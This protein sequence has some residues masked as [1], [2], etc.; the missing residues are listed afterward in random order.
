MTLF[1]QEH[2]QERLRSELE[3]TTVRSAI[4]SIAL[5]VIYQVS[6]VSFLGF[7]LYHIAISTAL[8]LSYV[9]RLALK[10]LSN[11]SNKEWLFVHLIVIMSHSTFWS[12]TLLEIATMDLVSPELHI[13]TYLVFAGLIAA[14]SYTLSIS[15]YDFFA[16]VLPIL[17]TQI[18]VIFQSFDYLTLKISSVLMILLF[19]NFLIHQRRRMEKSW[20]EQRTKNFEMQ[21]I[22]DAVPG[23]LSVLKGYNY[24]LV[25]KYMRQATPANVQLIGNPIGSAWNDNPQFTSRIREFISSKERRLQYETELSA[26]GEVRTYLVTA[27]KSFNDETIISIIDIEEVKQIEREMNAQKIKLQQSAKMAAL[28][29]MASGLAHEINNPVAIISGRA[30]QL[31]LATKKEMATKEVLLKGLLDINTTAERINRIVKGLRSFAHDTTNEPLLPH[32]LKDIVEDTLTFCEAK[33]RNNGIDLS[34]SIPDNLEILCV[35][36]QISQVILNALNN[37]HDAIAHEETNKWIRI[38]AEQKEDSIRISITDS[39]KGIIPDIRDKL[40]QP[41]FTTKEVGKGTGLGLSISKGIINAHKGQI[42]FNYDNT[43]NTE[44]VIVLPLPQQQNLNSIS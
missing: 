1:L 28:G 18:V 15:K 41:F 29:E 33:L 19:F 11:L 34:Y 4:A 27:V 3:E 26:M 35:P 43:E 20:I 22:V 10:K 9:C 44:L 25:N 7:N 24:H 21:N 42:F 6:A 14:A 17:G 8:I 2:L 37:S 16:F 40:M 36:T 39:G 12:L 38:T 32:P 31:I 30:Q 13:V 5:I 23:G